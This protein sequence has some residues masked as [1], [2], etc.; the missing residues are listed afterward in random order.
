MAQPEH[1]PE[2]GPVR[3]AAL[4]GWARYDD[5]L[6]SMHLAGELDDPVV[7]AALSDL[8]REAITLTEDAGVDTTTGRLL[9]LVP[10]PTSAEPVA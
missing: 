3:L 9:G 8:Y 5:A 4:N 7:Q 1:V 10:P 2:R 6:T